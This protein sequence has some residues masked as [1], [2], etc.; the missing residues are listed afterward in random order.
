MTRG[1]TL[2]TGPERPPDVSNL[3]L[4][5]A[6][7][8]RAID[9]VPLRPVPRSW[10]SPFDA[11][12]RVTDGVVRARRD[13]PPADLAAMDGYAV[14]FASRPAT[15]RF[16]L[17]PGLVGIRS[18][19]R[20]LARGEAIAIATGATLPER[21]DAVVR[22]ERAWVR[23]EEVRVRRRIPRGADIHR[24]GD[25]VRRGSTLLAP[26]DPVRP[27]HAALLTA[28]GI[29]RVPVRIVRVVVQPVGDE[30]V[31]ADAPKTGRV[32]D[33]LSPLIA[34]LLP[35]TKVRVRPPVRDE[36]RRLARALR[37]AARAADLVVTIGGTSV[38]ERDRTK[39]TVAL[40][41]RLVFGGVRVNVLKRG[42][43]GLLGPVPVVML[44]GQ[45]VAAVTTWHEHGARVL[46]RLLG[47]APPRTERV[48]LARRLRNPHPMDA[49][50]LLRIR[51]GRAEP[52]RWGPRLYSQLLDADGFTIVPRGATWAR[53]ARIEVRSLQG[54]G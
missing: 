44:P 18:R 10:V 29:R 2:T 41:G 28:Q 34:S 15:L 50:Y 47:A 7:A 52:A 40:V 27:Y 23:G 4:P 17:R 12:G 5:L 36:G 30:L 31:P 19:G 32:V 21:A 49:V 26:G 14:R 8:R 24:H 46:A 22:K 13:E 48:R 54:G 11:V 38:G 37:S 16:R 43:F 1:R 42:G 9:R 51:G 20:R 33:S 35:R 53:G 25:D 6:E 39:R 3:L 45:V